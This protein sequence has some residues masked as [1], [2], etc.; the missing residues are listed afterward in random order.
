MT[1]M[2]NTNNAITSLLKAYQ[3]ARTDVFQALDVPSAWRDLPI[4]D[5][6]DKIW[7]VTQDDYVLFA[8]VGEEIE[9]E[10][11]AFAVDINDYVS[12]AGHVLIVSDDEERRLM[13]FSG[14]RE[15]K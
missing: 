5:M 7:R 3:N 10:S 11:V 15:V 9:D 8:E 6:T 2:P 1:L 13:I 14:E 4:E 12:R